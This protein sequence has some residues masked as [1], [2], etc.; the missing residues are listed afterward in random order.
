MNYKST[1]INS[2]AA[3]AS[4]RKEYY[5]AMTQMAYMVEVLALFVITAVVYFGLIANWKFVVPVVFC[6]LFAL[7][8][9]FN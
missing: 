7:A 2:A 3:H 5:E 9:K 8:R 6:T 1:D 4:Q